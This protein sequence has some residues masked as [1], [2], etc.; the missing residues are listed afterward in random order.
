MEFGSK[1]DDVSKK[2]VK[3]DSNLNSAKYAHLQK[4]HLIPDLDEGK[5]FQYDRSCAIQNL[6]DEG[7]IVMKDWL[8]QSPD[9]II[10]NQM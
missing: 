3:K 1:S 5:I 6:V 2:L 7:V 8:A 4:H 10:I 9:L